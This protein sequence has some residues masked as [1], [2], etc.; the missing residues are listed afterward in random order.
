MVGPVEA[1]CQ[2]SGGKWIVLAVPPPKS[3]QTR[4]AHSRAGARIWDNMHKFLIGPNLA[5]CSL[6]PVCSPKAG[7]AGFF[8]SSFLK[9]RTER[10]VAELPALS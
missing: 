3:L 8:P 7:S 10:Q 2:I 6:S 9:E 5:K 1:Q 4:A